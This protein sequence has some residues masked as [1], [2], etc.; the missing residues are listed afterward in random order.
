MHSSQLLNVD[1]KLIFDLAAGVDRPEVIAQSYNLDP[2]FLAE[3]VETPHVKSMIAQKRKELVDNGFVLAT[4]AKL[5]FEDLLPDIYR[6][7]KGENVSLAS[8]LDA[9]KFL[10]TVAGLD[11][12]DVAAGQERFSIQININNGSSVSVNVTQAAGP[13][14]TNE[15]VTLDMEDV[16]DPLG[17]VP[18]YVRRA[19]PL[20]LELADQ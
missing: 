15:P 10:R 4:K 2:D 8:L 19:A 16:D 5:M 7:A 9:A 1:P 20:T 18:E 17:I 3:L 11:K 6:R 14:D 12:Q 13:S